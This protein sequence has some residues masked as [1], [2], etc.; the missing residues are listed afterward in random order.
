MFSLKFYY[1]SLPETGR[2]YQFLKNENASVID[3]SS[4]LM[5]SNYI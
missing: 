1:S 5:G 2:L 4:F 3:Q